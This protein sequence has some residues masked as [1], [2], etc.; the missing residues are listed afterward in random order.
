LPLAEITFRTGAAEEAIRIARATCPDMLV[1]AGTVTST[2]MARK[3]RDAGSSFIVTPGFNPEVVAW[4]LEAKIPVFPGCTTASEVE[5]AMNMGLD[6]VK[7]FPAEQSGGLPRIK[8]LQGPY[9][10][11]RFMPTGGIDLANLA[12]YLAYPKVVACGG[13]FM[14]SGELL[15]AKNWERVEELARKAVIAAQGLELAYSGPDCAD[16]AAAEEALALFSRL[17]GRKAA[18]DNGSIFSGAVRIGKNGGPGSFRMGF[19]VTSLVRTKAYC[20]HRGLLFDPESVR[21]DAAGNLAGMSLQSIVAGC[22][23]DILQR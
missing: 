9:P 19:S 14:A 18:Q 21:H 5:A 12:S 11:M 4:C 20:E 3:A 10:G 15:R 2:A 1:G 23:V 7:F 6:T 16:S 13:S 22:R 17:T 8:A